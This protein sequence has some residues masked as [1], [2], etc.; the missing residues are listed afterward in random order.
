[1]IDKSVQHF[2]TRPSGGSQ[3]SKPMKGCITSVFI[4]CIHIKV[5]R[6]APL[7]TFKITAVRVIVELGHSFVPHSWTEKR[8]LG[9]YRHGLDGLKT[10]AAA[11]SSS[12]TQS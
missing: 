8:R 7:Q 9:F 1:M 11:I 12:L 2:Y 6:Q 3:I 10:H 4:L 5:F